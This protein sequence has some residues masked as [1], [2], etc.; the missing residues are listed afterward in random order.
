MKKPLA[1]KWFV[2][3]NIAKAA[4]L[5]FLA[6]YIL[7]LPFYMWLVAIPN[8]LVDALLPLEAV[9]CMGASVICFGWFGLTV[10]ET[11]QL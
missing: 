7:T 6:V 4:F 10:K 3:K 5:F 1:L 2:A 11:L 9:V 8:S